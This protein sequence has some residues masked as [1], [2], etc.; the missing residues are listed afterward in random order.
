[1]KSRKP[2]FKGFRAKQPKYGATFYV[3]KGV[4]HAAARAFAEGGSTAAVAAIGSQ[5]K[6]VQLAPAIRRKIEAWERT[7]R[8][9]LE[10]GL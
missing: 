8:H 7:A 1:M 4:T 3:G 5:S 10:L 2:K 6:F 9:A